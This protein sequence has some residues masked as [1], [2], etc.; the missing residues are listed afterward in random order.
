MDFAFKAHKDGLLKETVETVNT[1]KATT[2]TEAAEALRNA[3]EQIGNILIENAALIRKGHDIMVN[4][5]QYMN[6]Y[7]SPKTDCVNLRKLYEQYDE[8]HQ[9][10]MEYVRLASSISTADGV[11]L[12]SVRDKLDRA[13]SNDKGFISGIMETVHD[14]NL[15]TVMTQ[16]E[17]AMDIK[18][19]IEN[20]AQDMTI[21][22]SADEP[23]TVDIKNS[24]ESLLSGSLG[25]YASNAVN[26]VSSA[27]DSLKNILEGKPRSVPVKVEEQPPDNLYKML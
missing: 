16:L 12:E 24:A 14:A 6:T 17:A 27:V 11:N 25:V 19:S 1:D 21:P 2:L 18:T 10:M 4:G 7:A 9:G 8:Y 20:Y 13:K 23:E 15:I 3:S 22:R 26:N 5:N